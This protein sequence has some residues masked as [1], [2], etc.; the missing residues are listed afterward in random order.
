MSVF[1]KMDKGDVVDQVNQET[2]RKKVAPTLLRN[3]CKCSSLPTEGGFTQLT[4]KNGEKK[5]NDKL[6]RNITVNI[7]IYAEFFTHKN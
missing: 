6:L 2:E 5:I 3:V 7:L 1:N 4:Q